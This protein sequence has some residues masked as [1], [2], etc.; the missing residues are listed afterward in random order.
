MNIGLNI[1]IF[2]TDITGF[3]EIKDFCNQLK[4]DKLE[5]PIQLYMSKSQLE[6]S[7]LSD[8][9]IAS[10][11]GLLHRTLV[12]PESIFVDEKVFENQ[13]SYINSKIDS[14]KKLNCKF[15]SLCIDPYIRLDKIEARN[16]FLSRVT[17]LAKLLDQQ[18]LDLNLE[19]ISHK[20]CPKN[21]KDFSIF[22][23]SLVEACELIQE[24]KLSNV[25]LLLDSLHYYADGAN[26]DL[27]SLKDMIGLV[28][29]C[30]YQVTN[31]D[32]WLDEKRVLP[33]EGN[34]P[35]TQFISKLK[36][37]NYTGDILIEVFNNNFYNPTL[38]QVASSLKFL[39][40]AYLGDNYT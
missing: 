24:L 9:N 16:L 34:L 4:I 1:A 14:A 23:S 15:F 39:E 25:K 2:D 6:R 20:V 8:F 10:V 26:F 31:T 5:I 3:S 32:K 36:D 7:E 11:S 17:Y 29:I 18:G 30:D 37:I 21:R 22:C 33:S 38:K 35:L 40:K 19:Y 12:I 28:H 13:L 27:E